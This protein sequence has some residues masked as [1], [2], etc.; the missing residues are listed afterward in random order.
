M[1]IVPNCCIVHFSGRINI[2]FTDKNDSPMSDQILFRNTLSSNPV[3]CLLEAA[4]L[5]KKVSY[6]NC[7]ACFHC[8]LKIKVHDA[9]EERRLTQINTLF[10]YSLLI[11]F[12][13]STQCIKESVILD[14]LVRTQ[15]SPRLPFV[16]RLTLVSGAVGI[17]L[18]LICKHH[19]IVA[20][21]L[22]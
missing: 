19:T 1:I 11:L 4:S 22:Q 17:L 3:K 13:Q 5:L 18:K 12:S 14:R 6:K 20:R 21:V 15:D 10:L 9:S 16:L 7:T 2:M 8:S